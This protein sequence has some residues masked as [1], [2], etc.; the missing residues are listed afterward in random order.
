[1]ILYIFALLAVRLVSHGLVFGGTAPPG[2]PEIFPNVPQS[3]FVLFQVM[4]GDTDMLG[5]LFE[6][7]PCT[8]I[9]FMIFTVLSSWAILSTLTAV[10]SESMMKAAEDYEEEQ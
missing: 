1:M 5:P 8:Q 3:I 6:V 10:I 2:I 9:V 4:N 7:L